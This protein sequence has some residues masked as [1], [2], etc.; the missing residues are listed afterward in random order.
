MTN[1]GTGSAARRAVKG[2]SACGSARCQGDPFLLDLPSLALAHLHRDR[3]RAVLAF[4]E[5][6]SDN[7]HAI[8]VPISA[9]AA[10][11]AS[12]RGFGW[13]CR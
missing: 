5:E 9:P 1:L 11:H 3:G 13:R 8:G 7:Q 12:S 2:S 10:M 6:D 4:G